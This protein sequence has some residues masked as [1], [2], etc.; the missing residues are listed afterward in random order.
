LPPGAACIWWLG[1][2]LRRLEPRR[3]RVVLSALLYAILLAGSAS[4]TS[5][6]AGTAWANHWG[7]AVLALAVLAAA[8]ADAVGGGRAAQSLE[9]EGQGAPRPA[10]RPAPWINRAVACCVV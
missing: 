7:P 1:W 4:I 9:A 3:R 5:F 2:G 6:K 8:A 10:I